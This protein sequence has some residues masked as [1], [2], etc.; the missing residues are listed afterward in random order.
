MILLNTFV[1]SSLIITLEVVKAVFALFVLW[2]VRMQHWRPAR[3]ADDGSTTLKLR[4][5]LPRTTALTEELGQVNNNR[6]PPRDDSVLESARSGA[7]GSLGTRQ[8]R[9]G[10]GTGGRA[11]VDARADWWA[12]NTG[13]LVGM[14]KSGSR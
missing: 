13:G 7:E 8:S 4:K 5:A 10:C 6:T 3:D 1:P 2:D 14:S 9:S 12:L 11:W